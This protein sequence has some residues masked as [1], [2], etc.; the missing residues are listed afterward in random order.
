I[1]TCA[2]VAAPF[3][4]WTRTPTGGIPFRCQQTGDLW[5]SSGATPASVGS[6]ADPRLWYGFNPASFALPPANS[7][8]IGN[9]PPTLTYG[10][11]VETMD[12]SV[13]KEFRIGERRSLQLKA[14][15]FNALN[16]FNPGAPNTVP[17]LNFTAAN[18]NFGRILPTQVTSSGVIYGGAQVQA[19]HMVLSVRFTF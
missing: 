14:E 9:T 17:N 4:Y 10:P 15:A 6:K 2:D 5:L 13:Y 19:R 11:G 3:G 12:L 1:V 18:P 7:L 16:H 8:G